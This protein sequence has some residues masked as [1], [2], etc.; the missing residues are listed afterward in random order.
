[1]RYNI[2]RLITELEVISGSSAFQGTNY[3]V[4]AK[5]VLGNIFYY[6]L[7]EQSA[8]ERGIKYLGILESSYGHEESAKKLREIYTI[9]DELITLF[10]FMDKNM[11]M[12]FYYRWIDSMWIDRLALVFDH[13]TYEGSTCLGCKIAK[14]AWNFIQGKPRH[15]ICE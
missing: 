12:N 15:T 13:Y 14:E 6:N 9:E 8:R 7:T 2:N 5:Y 11:M 3:D 4:K 1:M 10:S